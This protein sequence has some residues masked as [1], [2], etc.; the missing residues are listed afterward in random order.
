MTRI[1]IIGAGPNA[2]SHARYFAQSDRAE[3]VAVADVALDVA[4]K[5][6]AELNTEAVADYTEFLD[7]VD[8]VVVSS[9]N[10]LH[11]E[12]AIACARAGKHVYCEKP[13]GLNLE[14]ARDI[15]TAVK[16]AG[17]K[18][19]VGFATRFGSDVQ[20]MQRL[21]REGEFGDL[22][23]VC[24]RRL[25]FM[26]PANASRW[27][28]D[29]NLSGGL[30]YEVNIHEIDW[31]MCLGGEVQSVY[32]RTWA[33]NRD[34]ERS[35]DHIFVTLAF[36]NGANG[37]H[38]G[39]WLSSNP[40]YFRSVEGTRAGAATNEWG[41]KLYFAERG[42]GRNDIETDPAFDLRGH[43]L[44]CIQTD[45]TPVANVDWALKVMTVAE[46]ILLS[47]T[48]NRVVAMQELS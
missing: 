46:A 32:A 29:P 6:A 5:L 44:E 34:N 7:G 12:Q 38:E 42:K 30:L 9:P 40:Q 23:S 28:L 39:S 3:L 43:F 11:H 8:A 20:T 37:M 35:N 13:M 14:Q 21:N 36:A 10:F 31:M 17:V 1:G 33:A 41:T 22:I 25:G 15:A 26:D 27:R 16:D 47:A 18:S 4:Q 45:A 19:V 24:S 48:Q 2:V